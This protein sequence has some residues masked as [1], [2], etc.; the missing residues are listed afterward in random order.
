MKI[1]NG[2]KK[3]Y[4]D[5]LSGIYGIDEDIVYD[6]RNSIPFKELEFMFECFR[7]Y[8][9]PSDKKKKQYKQYHYN[10]NKFVYETFEEGDIFYFVIEI[11]FYQY[12]FK[13]ERYLDDNDNIH[14]DVVLCDKFKPKEKQSKAPISIIPVEYY[15]LFNEKPIIRKY[16]VNYTHLKEGA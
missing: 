15:G 10:G 5:Y 3:D 14:I 1:I 13:T 12:L 11:G 7:P 6:R 9:E 4:Y 16:I 2:G 8:K